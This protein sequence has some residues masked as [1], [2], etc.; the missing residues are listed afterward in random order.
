MKD[1][2]SAPVQP[3]RVGFEVSSGFAPIISYKVNLAYE[4]YLRA[5]DSLQKTYERWERDMA[6]CKG[7]G[8]KKG[9]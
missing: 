4:E 8:R 1:S 5:H 3:V 9:K 6:K 2:K 7:K